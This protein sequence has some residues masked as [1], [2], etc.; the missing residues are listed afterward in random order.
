MGGDED[1]FW[2]SA[3]TVALALCAS[4]RQVGEGALLKFA[5]G[6]AR[7]FAATAGEMRCRLPALAALAAFYPG[8][9]WTEL[10]RLC[11]VAKKPVSALNDAKRSDWWP[12]EGEAAFNAAMEALEAA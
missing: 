7:T 2:P 1:D 9:T 12:G 4:A 11:G 10:G 8:R 6:G 3:D 5:S